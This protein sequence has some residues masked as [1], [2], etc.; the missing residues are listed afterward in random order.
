[1][2]DRKSVFDI[3]RLKDA[4]CSARQ[5]A[6]ELRIG[7]TT[8]RK[9]LDHPERTFAVRKPRASKLDPYHEMIDA[10][11]AEAP[12]VKTPVVLQRLQQAGGKPKPAGLHPL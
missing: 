1:M 3:H 10:F 12:D 11:L 6:S 4:G 7:R 2:L 5:I 8:A 9:Y